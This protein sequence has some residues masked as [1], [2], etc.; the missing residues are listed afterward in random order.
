PLILEDKKAVKT[1]SSLKIIK[2]VFTLLDFFKDGVKRG[3]ISN[4]EEIDLLNKI[5]Y[6]AGY[7]SRKIKQILNQH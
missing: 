5:Y 4:E 6:Q 7:K 3:K 2:K 1:I